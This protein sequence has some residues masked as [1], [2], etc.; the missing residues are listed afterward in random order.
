MSEK[1]P[2]AV[3]GAGPV[4]LAAAAHL[5][6][7]NEP[8]LILE[9]GPR[10]GYAIEHWAHVRTF[11]PWRF[12]VDSASRALLCQIGWQE[13]DE[14]HVPTGREL[15]SDYLVPLSNHPTIASRLR[16]NAKVAQVSRKSL[17]KTGSAGRNLRPFEL[18]LID[19]TRIDARAVIDASGTWFNPNPMGADGTVVSGERENSTRIVY[20]IPDVLGRDR[21]RFSGKSVLVVGAG[22]SAINAVLDLVALRELDRGI[23]IQ[24]AMRRE[25]LASIYGCAGQDVLPARGAL[26][27]AAQD[28]IESGKVELYSPFHISGLSTGGDHLKVSGELNGCYFCTVVDEI[29]VAT[30]F[31][32]ISHRCERSGSAWIRSWRHPRPSLSSSTPKRTIAR[33]CR[34][35]VTPHCSTRKKTSTSLE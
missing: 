11:T 2:V 32:Q 5:A 20:G 17:D 29:V 21:A 19:G 30:G 23:R 3:I 34:H 33:P 9:Q 6:L 18:R 24:W 10:P 13:P 15:L 25:N 8:F 16:L 12:N 35:M 28:A 27:S 22:H 14:S 4:G 31:G 26:G 7:L 1:L